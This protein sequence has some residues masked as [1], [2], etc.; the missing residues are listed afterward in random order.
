MH[1]FDTD[2]E[3]RL[4]GDR[5]FQIGGETFT[6]RPSVAPE[7]LVRWAEMTVDTPEMEA[8]AIIDET[9]IAFLESGQAE[10]WQKVRDPDLPNPLNANDI[11]GL[12]RWLM[13]EQTGRPTS[14]S[15]GSTTGSA[16]GAPG[17]TLTAVPASPVGAG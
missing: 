4:L 14:P 12:V 9:I 3:N 1:N 11:S 10:K 6:Y 2:R 16:N 8:I 5:S 17:T 7:K 13:E 15:S